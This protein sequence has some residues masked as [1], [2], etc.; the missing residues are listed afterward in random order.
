MPL[1]LVQ[2]HPGTA[3]WMATGDA[4]GHPV[5]LS[6]VP[7]LGAFLY[8]TPRGFL[9]NLNLGNRILSRM[10]WLILLV[11]LKR[12]SI[13]FPALCWFSY[14]LR[15][16]HS[17]CPSVWCTTPFPARKLIFLLK[18]PEPIFVAFYQIVQNQ[19]DVVTWMS[20]GIEMSINGKREKRDSSSGKTKDENEGNQSDTVTLSRSHKICTWWT[21]GRGKAFIP[22]HKCSRPWMGRR[23]TAPHFGANIVSLPLG[24]F[25]PFLS[26]FSLAPYPLTPRVILQ[27]S[28]CLPFSLTL[29]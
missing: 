13:I 22:I 6:L 26:P 18:L 14:F 11:I 27:W 9:G 19:Y 16:A 23:M 1:P 12:P 5:Y 15:S 10:T 3:W 21:V 2:A 20:W 7:A 28:D 25:F 4:C 29:R 17:S 24:P 8:L